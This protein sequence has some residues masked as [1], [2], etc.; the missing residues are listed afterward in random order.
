MIN[1]Q[2]RGIYR[3]IISFLLITGCVD[4]PSAPDPQVLISDDLPYAYVL[5]EGLQ[6]SNQAEIISYYRGEGGFNPNI[7]FTSGN[8]EVIGDVGNS[9]YLRNDTIFSVMSSSNQ[10]VLVDASNGEL[11]KQLSLPNGTYPRY[12]YFD[13]NSDLYI[14]DLYN[15]R[16]LKLDISSGQVL[17]EYATG[18]APEEI[19]GYQGV[20]Y[21]TNSGL[22][23]YRQDEQYAGYVTTIKIVSGQTD[24]YKVGPNPKKLL[25]NADKTK[26]Y[27]GYLSYYWLDSEDFGASDS[28]VN[29]GGIIEFELPG[30]RKLREWKVTPIDFKFDASGNRMYVISDRGLHYIDIFSNSNRVMTLISSGDDNWYG[31]NI[32]K[33]NESLWICNSRDFQV[34]GEI[35]IYDLAKSAVSDRLESGYLPNSIVFRNQ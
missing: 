26:L 24:Y 5:C 11:I 7:R 14:T 34:R 22:G 35:V 30:M 20:V 25:F 1:N 4:T 17:A 33:V 27:V 23:Q 29:Q 12:M 13:D 18:P 8:S 15:D 19:V 2:I 28:L 32:D 16:V 31:L 10:I 6:G 9:F 3:V 21:V